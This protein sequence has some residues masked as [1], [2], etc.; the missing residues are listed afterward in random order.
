MSEQD[1]KPKTP[2][3]LQVIGS[4]LAAGFGVQTSKNRERDFQQGN[5]FTFIGV[6]LVATVA[7]ILVIYG[8]VRIVI[9]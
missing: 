6:G 1:Q 4:V 2:N 8:I 3:L 5:A 9:G 7:F